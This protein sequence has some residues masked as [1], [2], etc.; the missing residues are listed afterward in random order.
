MIRKIFV[1]LFLLLAA[2]AALQ[3]QETL[4]TLTLSSDFSAIP[5]TPRAVRNGFKHFWVTVWRQ[6]GNPA[7]LISKIIQS[8]GTA[9]A[10]KVVASGVSAFEG[11]FD[12]AYEPVNYTY[13]LA[14][15]TVKGLQVQFFNANFV[16]TGQPVLI[17]SGLTNSTPR[18]SYDAVGKKFLLFY[19]TTQ[20]GIPR[21]VLKSRNLDPQGKPLADART[22][23][24][25]AA[26][27]QFGFMSASRNP[28]TG[29]VLVLIMHNTSGSGE[30]LGYSVKADGSLQKPAALKV[31]PPTVGLNTMADASFADDGSGFAIW[32]DRT[33]TKYRKINAAMAFAGAAKSIVGGADSNSATTSIILDTRNVQYLGAWTK[34]NQALSLAL[35]PATGAVTKPPF[36]V[37]DSALTNSRNAA[38]SYDAALGNALVVWEDSSAP[39]TTAPAPDTKFRIRAAIY[40]VATAPATAT[41]SVGDNFFAPSQLTVQPGTT[42]KWTFDGNNP[43][44]VSSNTNLFDSGNENHGATFEFRFTDSGTYQYF[45][46]VH[47]Q[48][49]SGTITVTTPQEPPDHY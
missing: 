26:G 6:Q 44:T 31:Q 34:A 20:D 47:G 37:A 14:F 30:L 25:A 9:G 39:V 7:K 11:A 18:L 2:A 48:S 8:N 45:C 17:E 35:N 32:A 24:T 12:I 33:S 43:H 22:L 13:L 21:R 15:E 27:K 5:G 36:G 46:R 3:A 49:M 23:A 29:N 10:P 19:V 28:K 40:V 16:K 4:K 41:V 1:S 38:T 42:V